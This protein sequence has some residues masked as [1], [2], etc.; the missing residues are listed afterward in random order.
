VSILFT[1]LRSTEASTFLVFLLLGLHMVCEWNLGY[2]EL[3][4]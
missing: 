4:D 1:L 3:L 2:S